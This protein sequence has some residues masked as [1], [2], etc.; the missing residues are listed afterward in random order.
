MIIRCSTMYDTV[1]IKLIILLLSAILIG[2]SVFLFFIDQSLSW[3]TEKI[4]SCVI[5]NVWLFFIIPALR[6]SYN[7]N[8]GKSYEEWFKMGFAFGAS[9]IAIPLILAPYF[10]LV[11]YFTFKDN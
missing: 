6:N 8:R 11:Y 9:G 4:I 7:L 5:V 10:G 2:I 1:R 3:T